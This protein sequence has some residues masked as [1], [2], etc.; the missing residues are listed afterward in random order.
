[1]Q[2]LRHSLCPL[3]LLGGVIEKESLFAEV[4]LLETVRKDKKKSLQS[5]TPVDSELYPQLSRL[6]KNFSTPQHQSRKLKRRVDLWIRSAESCVWACSPTS[7]WI[8]G[9]LHLS[10]VW[11]VHVCLCNGIKAIL[12]QG[13]CDLPHTVHVRGVQGAAQPRTEAFLWCLSVHIVGAKEKAETEE[14]EMRSGHKG[15]EY[16][17]TEC[18]NKWH[19]LWVAPAYGE[20]FPVYMQGRLKLLNGDHNLY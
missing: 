12:Q 19:L 15:E 18:L 7:N 16:R 14:G 11:G 1:M 8:N 2:G 9:R 20:W 13:W 4:K 3:Q 17:F 10:E 6:S 5:L